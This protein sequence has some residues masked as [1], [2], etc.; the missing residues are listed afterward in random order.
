[1]VGDS[2][3]DPILPQVDRE[4]QTDSKCAAISGRQSR[5]SQ[6]LERTTSG[7]KIPI[8]T[9]SGSNQPFCHNTLCGQTDRSLCW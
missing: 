2:G 1:V 7:A 8:K 5:E 9:A 3:T 6:Y 4:L